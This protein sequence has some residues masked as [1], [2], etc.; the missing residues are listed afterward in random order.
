MSFGV[1]DRWCVIQGYNMGPM[2]FFR[3]FILYSTM[4]EMSGAFGR[5]KEGEASSG[6]VE[7]SFRERNRSFP[8]ATP[9]FH[10]LLNR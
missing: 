1:G 2:S 7:V 6:M 10:E 9:T 8:F 3:R 5:G 4:S